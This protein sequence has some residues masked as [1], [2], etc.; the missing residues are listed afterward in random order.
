M[1]EP[2]SG[3]SRQLRRAANRV[4]RREIEAVLQFGIPATQDIAP[5]VAL[6]RHLIEILSRTDDPHRASAAAG[7]AQ[8]VFEISLRRDPG[9]HAVVCQKGCAHCCTNFVS[10]SVPE[11]LALAHVVRAQWPSAEA[12]IRV[13]IDSVSARDFAAADRTGLTLPCPI[14]EGGA[15]SAY[16]AR[17][18]VCRGFASVSLDAC[19]RS[20]DDASVAIPNTRHRIHYRTQSAMALW[21][22]LKSLGLSYASYD[23]HHAVRV[24]VAYPDAEAEWLSGRAV[25]AEV[26]MDTSRKPE[27]ETFVDQWIANAGA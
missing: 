12:Q 18:L 11:I 3:A 6:T 13:R 21:A 19:I 15:C 4:R 16:A 1:A 9:R 10:A 8:S 14:L 5:T 26:Q 22:A 7:I 2:A 27:L 25:F 23:L 24:A 17:P 20:L